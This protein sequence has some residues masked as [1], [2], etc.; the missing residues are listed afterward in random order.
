M[1]LSALF[2]VVSVLYAT[3]GHAGASGYLAAMALV[4]TPAALMK[5]TSLGLNV[6][7][8][9]IASWRFARAGHFHGARLWPFALTSV[10]CAFLGGTLTLST[11]AYRVIVGI[12]LLVSAWQLARPARAS[13]TARGPALP[14]ALGVGAGIGLL[15]GLTGVGGGVF[16]TP[17]LVLAGWADT[18]T[19]AG[20]SAPFILLNSIS[21]LLGLVS[22]G[23]SA[24]PELPL[25]AVVVAIGGWIG[26][27]L[28]SRHLS[29]LTLRRLLAL[30]LLIAGLK[31]VGAG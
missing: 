6:V 25:W 10:P 20:I 17:L 28:G 31:L 16:L 15:S 1:L 27:G 14:L 24:P 29:L 4:G 7:V 3:V 9:T 8:A 13:G 11:D 30:V 21:G 5:P 18:R 2:F 23:A 26:A 22:T 19:A 12:A